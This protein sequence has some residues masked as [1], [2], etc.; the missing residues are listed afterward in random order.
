M[1]PTL[2]VTDEVRSME[3]HNQVTLIGRTEAR[4]NSKIVA[5]VSGRVIGIN[6]PEG[7]A[8]KKGDVL[9]SIEP[10][11]IALNLA[12]KEA[13]VARA[14]TQMK[15]AKSNLRRNV[16]LFEQKLIRQITLDSAE[17]WVAIAEADYRRLDA[18][19]QR[20]ALD[21]DHCSIRAPYNGYT[22]RRMIDVG[23]W[24][25]EGTPVFE[26][27][28]LSEMKVQVDLPERYYGRLARGSEV[29]VTVSGDP[30]NK[31]I[32]TV[33][34][35]APQASE[36]THTFPVIVTIKNTN[37]KM[38]G[39]KLVRATLTLDDK[40]TSL[41]VSKDAIV[42]QGSQTLIYTVA[43]G[44][45]VP[46][47]VLTSSTEGEMI[48]IEGDGLQEGMPVVVRGNE[49]IFPGSPVQISEDASAAQ[50][51]TTAATSVNVSDTQE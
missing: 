22:L 43:D 42:R 14:E 9:V 46:I 15:L 1:P 7:N 36:A 37:G 19:R 40:F 20:L 47:P 25:S 8:V 24:V 35:I 33:T 6:A 41:A 10:D 23:E 4:S 29:A 27:V 16:E 2:V 51:G 21:L 44:K 13:E 49:R 12:A 11:R 32:G 30:T 26:M 39:G 17:A 34:G 28:D 3:F 45:A 50:A 5:E 18:E 38:G 31:F 48:A